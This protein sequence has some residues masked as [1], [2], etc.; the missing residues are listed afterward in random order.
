M[1]QKLHGM[2]HMK[3]SFYTTYFIFSLPG[4]GLFQLQQLVPSA[5][6]QDSDAFIPR[7]LTDDEHVMSGQRYEF[8]QTPGPVVLIWMNG[9]ACLHCYADTPG[10]QA[11]CAASRHS[12]TVRHIRQDL[13]LP[14]G[15][16][17]GKAARRRSVVAC[18]H[19]R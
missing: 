15:H 18:P 6:A 5:H 4:T 1:H 13:P 11:M 8:G 9:G 17:I 10:I 3:I 7:F 12:H 2:Y 16:P 19:M 14:M